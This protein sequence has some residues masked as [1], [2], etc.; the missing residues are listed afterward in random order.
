MMMSYLD[1]LNIFL[2]L[3]D[4]FLHWTYRLLVQH[5]HESG[6]F[7][8]VKLLVEQGLR[9][10]LTFAFLKCCDPAIQLC[11]F[12]NQLVAQSFELFHYELVSLLVYLRLNVIQV[13]KEALL[14]IYH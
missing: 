8:S 10:T 12:G 6:E 11:V 5:A 13:F 14:A 7:F 9:D 1:A 2:R 4:L 3:I